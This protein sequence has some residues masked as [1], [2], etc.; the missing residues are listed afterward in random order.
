MIR[1]STISSGNIFLQY[2]N[3]SAATKKI[4]INSY[5]CQNVFIDHYCSYYTYLLKYD[6]KEHQKLANSVASY[7]KRIIDHLCKSV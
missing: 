4:K 1:R 7:F 3:D 2:M 5:A 6:F